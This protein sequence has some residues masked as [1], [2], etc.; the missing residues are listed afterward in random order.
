MVML[1]LDSVAVSPLKPFS[2]TVNPGDRVALSGES[3]CG[4]SRFLHGLADLI[5][6]DGSVSLNGT[7]CES[8]APPEWRRQ[9]ML[10]P[11]RIEWWFDTALEHFPA[12]PD[13]EQLVALNLKTDL[14][15]KP[16]SEL[17]TGQR[18]RLAILRAL[19]RNPDILLLD[20]PTANLDGKNTQAVE[21]LMLSW[22][23]AGNRAFIWC[24]HDPQQIARIANRHWQVSEQQ[25][26]ETAL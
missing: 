19:A 8:T 14:L 7:A 13:E 4:K 20:E 24:S 16:V 11:S 2:S 18:Q 5:P 3:G 23:G 12:S 1:A 6:H 17:S 26:T 21:T 15:T 25:I 10:L 22:V 9:V